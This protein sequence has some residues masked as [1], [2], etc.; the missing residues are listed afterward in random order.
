MNAVLKAMFGALAVLGGLGGASAEVPKEI[1]I[2]VA[3]I[4]LGGRPYVGSSVAA[5][6]HV[7][8]WLEEEFKADGIRVNWH[9]FKTAGPGVNEAYTNGKLDFAWQGDLPQLI[10][11]ASGLKT[12]LILGA[13]R[14][15]YFYLAARKDS[16]AKGIGDIKGR[17]VA[18]QKGTC[19]H[20]SVARLLAAHG[21][22]EKDLK[23]YNLDALAA[24]S[25]LSSG[26]L[27]LAF[28]SFNLLPVRDQGL[29]KIIYSGAEDGGKYGCS[30][31]FT[32]TEGFADRHPD[33]TRR[34]VKILVKA[35]HWAAQPENRAELYQ[36]WAKSGVEV[37]YFQ[38]E[39]DSQDLEQ[40][41][42]PLID[43]YQV[44]RYRVALDDAKQFGL[45][46]GSVD[47]DRWIDRSYLDAALAELKLGG[48]WKP[49][50]SGGKP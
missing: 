6:A 43:D 30:T 37:K 25:A 1:N 7:K 44:N 3:S 22:K 28:G 11:R 36:I 27:E 9:F 49:E 23:V 15:Q 50:A 13:S 31:G 17:S 24:V 40:K 16:T 14:R 33:L 19:P 20:L 38:E 12:R 18:I 8:G 10:G 45:V 2:G 29:V 48:F 26:D 34:V 47:F 35:A 4:G 5:V 39:W 21:F 41:F 42:S 46:R 32:V